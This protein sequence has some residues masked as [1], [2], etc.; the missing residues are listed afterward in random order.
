MISIRLSRI[1]LQDCN[2]III[3]N[4]TIILNPINE[5]A[6]DFDTVAKRFFNQRNLQIITVNF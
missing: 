2:I 4:R 3:C 5:N 1:I 6:N